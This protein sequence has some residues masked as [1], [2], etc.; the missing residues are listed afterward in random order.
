MQQIDSVTILHSI[1]QVARFTKN[2]GSSCAWS[3]AESEEVTFV[4]E[5]MF[6]HVVWHSFRP[7]GSR[8]GD[9]ILSRMTWHMYALDP[10]CPW[11]LWRTSKYDVWCYLDPGDW[12]CLFNKKLFSA[13][14]KN[15][16]SESRF[17]NYFYFILFIYSSHLYYFYKIETMENGR[18]KPCYC[19]YSRLY[20]VR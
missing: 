14:L 3:W 9:N 19:K 13:L 8:E 12:Q 16:L 4:D 5:V 6:C 2:L 10:S 1:L 11:L 7:V 18:L 15:I 17:D 20:R